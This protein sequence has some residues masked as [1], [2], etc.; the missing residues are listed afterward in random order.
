[1]RVERD[2]ATFARNDETTKRDRFRAAIRSRRD[3]LKRKGDAARQ[4]TRATLRGWLT[5][6][7]EKEKPQRQ[8]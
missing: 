6:K 2:A 8:E 5:N 1:M 7:L 4:T 3:G